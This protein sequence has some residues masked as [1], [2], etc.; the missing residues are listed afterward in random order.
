[1]SVS[2]QAKELSAGMGISEPSVLAKQAS[3]AL[4]AHGGDVALHAHTVPPG[5]GT[6]PMSPVL[7]GTHRGH[8]LLQKS[9]MVSIK[10]LLEEGE[11]NN[12]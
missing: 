6:P 5:M 3:L 8:P 11:K 2:G 1:M 7:P 10:I 12:Q 4:P 9:A